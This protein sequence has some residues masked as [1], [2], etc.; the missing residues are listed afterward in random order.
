MTLIIIIHMIVCFLLIGLILVQ[1]GRGGGLVDSFSSVESMLGTK[2]NTLLTRTT[3]VLS[4]LFFVT[5]LSLAL[6]SAK[7]SRSL[8]KNTETQAQPVIPAATSTGPDAASA[9]A[10]AAAQAVKVQD[11][12]ATPQKK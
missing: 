9:V 1:A 3:T 6:L 5:C 10:A 11:G 7:Q 4:I 12:K 2:T 8:M